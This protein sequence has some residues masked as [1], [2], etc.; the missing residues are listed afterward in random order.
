MA[1]AFSPARP[2]VPL[3]D[4]MDLSGEPEAHRQE[5]LQQA[6]GRIRKQVDLED[7]RVFRAALFDL[8]HGDRSLILAVHHLVVDAISLRILIEDLQALWQQAQQGAPFDL[9]PK[10]TPFLEWAKMLESVAASPLLQNELPYWQRLLA[11]PIRPL[12]KDRPDGNNTVASRAYFQLKAPVEDTQTLL[13]DTYRAYRMRIHEVLIT[14]ITRAMVRWNGSPGFFLDLEGHGRVDLGSQF[15]RDVSRTVGWFTTIYPVYLDVNARNVEEDLKTVKEALREVPNQGMGF[16]VLQYLDQ[17]SRALLQDIPKPEI[18]FNYLGQSDQTVSSDD[19]TFAGQSESTAEHSNVL[20]PHLLEMQAYVVRGQLQFD[21]RYGADM[22]DESTVRLLGTY[23]LEELHTV[24][25]HCRTAE[26]SFTPSDFPMVRLT[27]QEIHVLQE[28]RRI[29]NLYPLSPM[30]QGILFHSLQVPGAGFYINQS[31][32]EIEGALDERVFRLAWVEAMQRH[33]VLRTSFSWQDVREPLQIVEAIDDLQWKKLDWRNLTATEQ[34]PRLEELLAADI[35]QDFDL[36]TAPMMRFVLI[37]AGEDRVKLVWTHHH[38]ILDGWAV[39]GLLQDV[40]RLYVAYASG[41][42]IDLPRPRPYSDYI[43]WLS[44]QDMQSAESFWRD[45]LRGFESTTRLNLEND[46][47]CDEN[48]PRF[49][50]QTKRLTPEATAAIETLRQRH[51][52]TLNTIVQAAWGL[53]LCRYTGHQVVVF[54]ATTSG[55][56]AELAGADTMAGLFINTLPVRVEEIPGETLVDLLTKLQQQQTEARRFEYSSLVQ[57]QGW[58]EV[59]RDQPLFENIFVFENYP[60]DRTSAPPESSVRIANIKVEEATHYPLIALGLPGESLGLQ[61]QYDQQKIDS[62]K[63]ERL[64]EHWACLLTRMADDPQVPVSSLDMMTEAEKQQIVEGWNHT[65]RTYQPETCIHQLI[66]DQVRRTPAEI[67]VVSEEGSLSYHELNQKSNQLAHYLRA[68]GVDLESKVGLCLERSASMVVS[69]LAVLKAGG[70]YVPLEPGYPPERLTY[71][72]QDSGVHTLVTE[73]RFLQ[74]LPHIE[75]QLI[76]LEE[77]QYEIGCCDVNNIPSKV[78]GS[79]AAYVIYTSGSTGVPKGAVNTHEGIRNRIL[80]MQERYQLQ[81]QDR[82]LQKTPFSFDVSVWEFLWPLMSG[83]RLVVAR[84][85]GHKDPRY[86]SE[87]IKKEGITV[88]HFVPS[89]LAEFLE[90]TGEPQSWKLRAV[91]SSGEELSKKTVERFFKDM[92]GVQLHNLYGPTEAAVDVTSYTCTTNE[93][94]ATISIGRPIANIQIYILNRAGML[95]PVGVPGELY[96]G[97]LGVG[98]GYSNRPE[99][100]AERFVPD[101][102]ALEAG[103]RLYRSGDLATWRED[104]NIEFLGRND[105]QVKV[106]GHRIELGEIEAVIRSCPGVREAAV[107]TRRDSKGGLQILAYIVASV[108]PTQVQRELRVQLPDYM[109]PAAIV[110]LERLPLTSNGKLDRKASPQYS[111]SQSAAISEPSGEVELQLA[112]LFEDLLGVSPIGRDQTFFDLGGHSLLALALLREVKQQFGQ[113]IALSEFLQNPTIEFLGAILQKNYRRS[114]LV[115]ISAPRV[116]KKPLSSYTRLAPVRGCMLIWLGS[117]PKMSSRSMASR[118]WMIEREAESSKALSIE[119]R[120]S[121]YLAELLEAQPEGPYHIGGYS[122]GGYVAYDK[123]RAS[124]NIAT[125]MLRDCLLLDLPANTPKDVGTE[126]DDAEYVVRYLTVTAKRFGGNERLLRGVT[127]L[128]LGKISGTGPE[129]RFRNVVNQLIEHRIVLGEVEPKQVRHYVLGARRREEALR[130]YVLGAYQGAALLVRA[131][132]N[133]QILQSSPDPDD[134]TLGWSTLCSGSVAVQ[135]VPGT[136]KTFMQPPHIEKV[137]GVL[138]SYLR[139]L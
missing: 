91:M 36:T 111:G 53:V 4:V 11:Y 105:F 122:F 87:V 27:Q 133:L 64:L 52:L 69:I 103:A 94:H 50:R 41:Q 79:N 38:I 139:N 31:C 47:L 130:D 113:S 14:A 132:D 20:R 54:G 72:L 128:D 49:M 125:K 23:L 34:E 70:A 108:D 117:W 62:R 46:G 6:I 22:Q 29:V 7:G 120:A 134:I 9:P 136:H 97:G 5:K 85:E 40:L 126:I 86:L 81:S 67:A 101:P 39:A 82:V 92:R 58:S 24:V 74:R 21:V 71:M 107:V 116:S 104:G 55:R 76:C 32:I 28:N 30:Q 114:Q 106:R 135:W 42:S 16:G 15:R 118:C 44:R 84:P 75:T 123:W 93:Q 33:T 1:A 100:T 115:P 26:S 129:E 121:A 90:E 77:E 57:I 89:M 12:R 102:F 78:Q 65:A 131:E 127:A 83:A 35:K 124:F 110:K 138:R 48:G 119:E 13:R 59:P 66:E 43:E 2:E 10:T 3:L 61:F 45:Y 19:W 109:L 95:C 96:I 37:R 25:E 60:I 137:A 18:V 68:R 73:R 56:P 98:R 8:G 51:H 80:W 112:I 17:P 63:V 88:L 99:L